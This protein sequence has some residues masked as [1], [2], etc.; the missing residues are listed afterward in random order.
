MSNTDYKPTKRPYRSFVISSIIY[1]CGVVVFSIWSYTAQCKL[2]LSHT[3]QTSLNDEFLRK[4]IIRNSAETA[5]LILMAMPLVLLYRQGRQA[6]KKDLEQLNTLLQQEIELQKVR[7][8]ELKD[9]IHDLERFNAVSVGRET[10]IIEL[11]AEVNNLL[12]DLNRNN[13]YKIGR[14]E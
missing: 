4:L 1:A 9:A 7:E 5:F 3:N 2:T 6:V 8:V 14:N 12:A 11:K 10:R 13:L